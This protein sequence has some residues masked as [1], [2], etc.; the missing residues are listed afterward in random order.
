M[1]AGYVAI[2]CGLFAAALACA[3][4][5]VL[6]F[7]VGLND[8]DLADTI[9]QFVMALTV[10]L[11]ALLPAFGALWVLDPRIRFS[12]LL[13]RPGDPHTATVMASKRGGRTMIL[14]SLG[15]APVAGTSPCPRFAS[16]RG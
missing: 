15:T 11:C 7:F 9:G 5:A 6:V 3:T 1:L 8:L 16:R 14:T 13:R 12:R 2:A 4:A 10:F